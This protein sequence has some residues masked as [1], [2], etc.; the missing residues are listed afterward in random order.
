ML[1]RWRGWFTQEYGGG[2]PNQWKTSEF[3]DD[4]KVDTIVDPDRPFTYDTQHTGVTATGGL[5]VN[6]LLDQIS[7]AILSQTLICG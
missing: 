1:Q 5:W 2:V 6:T 7:V 3:A 4:G